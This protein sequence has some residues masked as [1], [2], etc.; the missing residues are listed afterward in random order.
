MVNDIQKRM[1]DTDFL[2]LCSAVKQETYW[3]EVDVTVLTSELHEVLQTHVRSL[4]HCL[5]VFLT[6]ERS[7]VNAAQ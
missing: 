6:V 3:V 7:K 5:Q 4:L 1:S 2:F